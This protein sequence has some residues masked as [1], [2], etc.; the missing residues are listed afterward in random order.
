M[1]SYERLCYTLEVHL[2]NA[3]A[4]TDI[5]E[6]DSIIVVRVYATRE[7]APVRQQ[8]RKMGPVAQMLEG[9]HAIIYIWSMLQHSRLLR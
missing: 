9:S 2:E 7:G 8:S 4:S 3:A 6:V 5:V 1:Q